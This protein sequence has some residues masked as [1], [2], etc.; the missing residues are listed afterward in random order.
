MPKIRNLKNDQDIKG[1]EKL[2][3]TDTDTGFT[4]NFPISAIKTYID[5]DANTETVALKTDGGIIKENNELLLSTNIQKYRKT[6]TASEMLAFNGGTKVKIIDAP[7]ANKVIV[8]VTQYF[9]MDFNSVAYNFS[10][11]LSLTYGDSTNAF[12]TTYF[13]DM[14]NHNADRGQLSSATGGVFGPF[15]NEAVYLGM[16]SGSVT[17]GDSPVTFLVTYYIL[18]L[19]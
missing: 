18:D 7:G 9:F 1:N 14:L 2:V 11:S 6:F 10:Q 17:Q 5:R 16:Q 13:N 19:S 4:F 15:I 3:G 8:P 12:G